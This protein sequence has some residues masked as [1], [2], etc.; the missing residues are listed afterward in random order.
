MGKRNRNKG[1]N[2]RKVATTKVDSFQEL[3]K[4]IVEE[5]KV[6]EQ[7]PMFESAPELPIMV[8]Q[9][10]A[11]V[12]VIEPKVIPFKVPAKAQTTTTTANPKKTVYKGVVVDIIKTEVHNSIQ[13]IKIGVFV[14]DR[15]DIYIAKKDDLIKSSDFNVN[16]IVEFEMKKYTVGGKE[17]R[18]LF[19]VKVVGKSIPIINEMIEVMKS[20]KSVRTY[21]ENQFRTLAT[22]AASSAKTVE[23]AIKSIED[24]FKWK[25]SGMTRNKFPMFVFEEL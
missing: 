4:I 10:E 16:D 8:K 5:Q 13:Y 12:Q 18:A 7:A 21:S 9:A 24:T 2:T 11:E 17:K 3:K 23:E 1:G 20:A 25:F 6:A 14:N 22:E 15:P 19:N